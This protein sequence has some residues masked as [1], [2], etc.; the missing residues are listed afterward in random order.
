M[1][2]DVRKMR[3]SL[4]LALEARTAAG[5]ARGLRGVAFSIVLVARVLS[6]AVKRHV[7]DVAGHEHRMPGD[8]YQAGGAG[9]DGILVLDDIARYAIDR[10]RPPG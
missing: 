7:L 8:Y 5:R 4:L 2:D 1:E 6:A 9:G 3:L 10:P